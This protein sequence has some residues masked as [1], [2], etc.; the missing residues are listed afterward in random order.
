MCSSHELNPTRV[1]FDKKREEYFNNLN[2][3]C[4][5]IDIEGNDVCW[6]CDSDCQTLDETYKI[7]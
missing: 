6:S 4:N 1:K 3:G 5:A 7:A 2:T